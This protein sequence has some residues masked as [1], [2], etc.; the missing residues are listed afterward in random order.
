MELRKKFGGQ[1]TDHV[2]PIDAVALSG[3][4]CGL[5]TWGFGWPDLMSW[6]GI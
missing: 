3:Q 6:D 4:S 1:S 5:H 2:D